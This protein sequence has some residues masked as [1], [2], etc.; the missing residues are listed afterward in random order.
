MPELMK[1][2]IEFISALIESEMKAERGEIDRS[3]LRMRSP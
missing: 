3:S 1:R 2:V